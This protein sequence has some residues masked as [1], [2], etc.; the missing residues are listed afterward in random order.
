M[1]G[2]RV[3]KRATAVA[4]CVFLLAAPAARAAASAP[5]DPLDGQE[6]RAAVQAIEGSASFPRGAFFPI[7]TLKEPRKADLLAWSP[8]KPFARAAFA[9]VYDPVTNRLFE[10]TVDLK[11]GP[12][13][14]TAFTRLQNTQ[15]AVYLTEFLTADAAVRDNKAWNDAIK[16]RGLK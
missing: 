5:Q 4:G 14:V 8:G 6:I 7:V 12:A 15:P 2:L 10:A 13:K 16:A 9:N 1:S 3:G 11:G